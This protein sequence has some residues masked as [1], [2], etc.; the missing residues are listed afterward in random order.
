MMSSLPYLD[1]P[2]LVS[3]SGLDG[4]G[5]T[6]QIA[7]LRESI[8]HLGLRSDLITFW[9]DVVVGT[10]YREGFVHK[11]YGSE[12]GVGAPGRPV[13]RR[14]KNVRAGYLTVMRH[15]LYF[16]DALH[17]RIV[18]R[19]ARRSGAKVIL[20][21]RYIYDELSNLPLKNRFSRGCA[22]LLARI[23]PRPQLALL[24][25]TDPAMARA[26][27]PEYSLDFMNQSRRSYFRLAQLLGDITI[28]PP[29]ALDDAKHSILT[30]FLRT[31][32]NCKGKS[33]LA[34][35]APVGR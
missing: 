25:D 33:E 28:V 26:R 30:S 14:D 23:A 17:L 13:E 34:G 20:L 3:F 6:T 19:R 18:L 1:E 29:L 8:T 22:R 16:A 12:K 24:L 21:D 4:S 2:I 5:K 35:T 31:L 32:E 9:D 10:R 11:V 27:K 15:L 7:A